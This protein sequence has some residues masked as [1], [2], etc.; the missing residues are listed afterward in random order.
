MA[1]AVSRLIILRCVL[2]LPASG[3]GT[4]LEFLLLLGSFSSVLV[5]FLFSSVVQL[6]LTS[7][8]CS[9]SSISSFL[10]FL[11]LLGFF[12]LEFCYL[13]SAGYFPYTTSPA[14]TSLALYSPS[15]ASPAVYFSSATSLAATSLALY[16]SCSN[17]PAVYFPSATS[18]VVCSPAVTFHA[19]YSPSTTPLLCIHPLLIRISLMNSAVCSNP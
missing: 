11:L 13:V 6:L 5:Q 15:S 12:S 19:V 4:L 10:Q 9:V 8:S 1:E 7:C 3:N 14:S 18:P 16:F 17:F 2:R